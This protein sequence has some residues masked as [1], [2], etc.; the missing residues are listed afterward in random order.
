[1]YVVQV[2]S[3]S[4]CSLISMFRSLTRSRY[5][6]FAHETYLL[7]YRWSELFYYQLQVSIINNV[8]VL[9]LNKFLDNHQQGVFVGVCNFA[10][11]P[12]YG[13]SLHFHDL[14]RM[15][16]YLPMPTRWCGDLFNSRHDGLNCFSLQT[17][18]T[19]V[20]TIFATTIERSYSR[21]C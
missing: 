10:W 18:L 6:S 21:F 15:P 1:M 3:F 5:Q 13:I 19:G 16:V 8:N 11:V 20:L 4:S 12:W 7:S 14:H 9:I 2:M 17:S